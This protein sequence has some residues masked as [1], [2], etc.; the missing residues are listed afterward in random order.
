MKA[1]IGLH[2]TSAEHYVEATASIHRTWDVAFGAV[3]L[4]LA[5]GAGG[6]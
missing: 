6:H 3:C 2:T 1:A 5:R 4:V